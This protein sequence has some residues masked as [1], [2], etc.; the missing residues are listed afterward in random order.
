LSL[1]R[2][3][4]MTVSYEQDFGLWDEQM[5]D[6]GVADLR[7]ESSF[8]VFLKPRAKLTFAREPAQLAFIP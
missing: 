1:E 3:K 5:A 6:L 2:D 7:Y 8:L 4:S